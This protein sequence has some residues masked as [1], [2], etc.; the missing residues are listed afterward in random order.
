MGG[1]SGCFL[2]GSQA[3]F[4]SSFV[5]QQYNRAL[6]MRVVLTVSVAALIGGWGIWILLI[7]GSS[8]FHKFASC[9]AIQ[10]STAMQWREVECLARPC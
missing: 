5:V 1:S 7:L 9:T 4:T 10:R 2:F 3:P 8:A 6:A